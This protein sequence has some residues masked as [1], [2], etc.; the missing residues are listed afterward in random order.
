M[1][2]MPFHFGRTILLFPT[3]P[4]LY[5]PPASTIGILLPIENIPV[6]WTRVRSTIPFLDSLLLYFLPMDSVP[7]SVVELYSTTYSLYFLISIL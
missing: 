2:T 6:I 3:L 4:A 5:E 7:V 1:G